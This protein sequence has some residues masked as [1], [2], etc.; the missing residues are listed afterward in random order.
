MYLMHSLNPV[1]QE[2]RRHADLAVLI[3]CYNEAAAIGRVVTDLRKALPDATIYVYDNNST[4]GTADVAREAGAVVRRELLQGKGNVIRRMFADIEADVYVVIDGDGTYDAT[5]APL[6]VE[7]LIRDDLDMVTGIRIADSSSAYRLGHQ[8]G[9]RALTGVV[10]NIFGNRCGDM[11]SGYRVLSR[12]FV[13]SFPAMAGGFEI[14]TELTV[15]ALELRMPIADMP[16]RYGSREAGSTSKLHTIRDG[17]RIGGMIIRLVKEERPLQFF[18]LIGLMF[19]LASLAFGY[20][21][22]ITFLETGQVPR[23]PSA[24]LAMGLMIIAF[25]SLTSGVI[26]DSITNGRRELRRLRY[27]DIPVF[28]SGQSNR[29][30]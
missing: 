23:F 26:L 15:H 13:K 2:A 1:T 27:L 19:F 4:D 10:A 28:R 7:R 9:N 3:P 16:T 11:L 21:V 30:S 18:S 8:F 14:E 29:G 20:P 6:L 17:L 25:L 12:R 24:I 5:A 22:L